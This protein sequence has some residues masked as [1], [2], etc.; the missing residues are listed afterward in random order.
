M[1]F[2]MAFWALIVLVLMLLKIDC[3]LASDV[4]IEFSCPHQ[5][6]LKLCFLSF[7]WCHFNKDCGYEV[8][9]K[10]H[11]V[12][13]WLRVCCR[14]AIIIPPFFSLFFYIPKRLLCFML[15]SFGFSDIFFFVLFWSFL[16]YKL[17]VSVKCELN[18]IPDLLI[19]AEWLWQIVIGSVAFDQR[20][21]FN[22]E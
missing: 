22:S 18:L 5:F 9:L 16:H 11:Y 19:R 12:M 21:K 3:P 15:H 10:T 7:K 14:F 20:C 13:K 2:E 17:W 6:Y 4:S 8:E 1:L